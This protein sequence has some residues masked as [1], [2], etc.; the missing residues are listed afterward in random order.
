MRCWIMRDRSSSNWRCPSGHIKVAMCFVLGS[1]EN[2]VAATTPATGWT[3]PRS[4]RPSCRSAS[5]PPGTPWFWRRG[6]RPGAATRTSP[7]RAPGA[8]SGAAP[9]GSPPPRAA[10]PRRTPC[11]RR[12][13]RKRQGTASTNRRLSAAVAPG[14]VALP[15]GMGPV[16]AHMASAGTVL[17]ASILS[18]ALLP[19]PPFRRALRRKWQGTRR[20]AT[21]LSTGLSCAE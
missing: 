18:P 8:P 13:V 3:P 7:G 12:P 14:P 1:V 15:G 19:V 6:S 21:Q 16:R 20:I 11:P 17:S 10:S 2:H 9:P 4:P 5:P